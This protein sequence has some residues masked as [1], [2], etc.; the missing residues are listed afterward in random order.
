VFKAAL[1]DFFS[2]DRFGSGLG[3]PGGFR[4]GGGA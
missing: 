3:F 1:P 4:T 2:A